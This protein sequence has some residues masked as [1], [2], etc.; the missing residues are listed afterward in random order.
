ME[1]GITFDELE[2]LCSEMSRQRDII[3][4][5]AEEKKEEEKILAELEKKLLVLFEKLGKTSYQS[6]EGTFGVSHR[7]SVRLP[8]SPE[9]KAEFFGFLRSKGVFDNLATV[10]SATLNSFYKAEFEAAKERGEGID[11]SIPG[12]DAPTINQIVT[13][14]AVKK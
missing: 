9:A 3:D 5:I 10:H 6:K 14:R 11:F 12:I 2:A 1:T 13:F 4:R 8:A 7:M